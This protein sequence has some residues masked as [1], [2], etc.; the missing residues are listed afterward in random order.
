MS[1]VD[2]RSSRQSVFRSNPF[3][4]V[5]TGDGDGFERRINPEK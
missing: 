4:A 3:N 2:W 1:R 5:I